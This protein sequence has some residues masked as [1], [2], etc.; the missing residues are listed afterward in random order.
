MSEYMIFTTMTSTADD[1]ARGNIFPHIVRSDDLDDAIQQ[2]LN[3]RPNHKVVAMSQP[4]MLKH[5]G[6]KAFTAIGGLIPP[7]GYRTGPFSK[8][9]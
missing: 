9:S 6:I 4:S 2:V 5:P 1:A 3:D 7:K 8:F